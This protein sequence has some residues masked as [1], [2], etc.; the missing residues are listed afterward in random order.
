[1]GKSLVTG[2]DIGHH[3]IKAVVLKLAGDSYVLVGYKELFITEDI[4]SDNHTLDYQKIVK[5]LKE[6]RKGLPLFS[7]KV[8][9]SVPD[10]AVISKVLQID[11]DLQ[12]REKEFAIYQA[13]SHQSPFPIE[14]L[15]LDFVQ[16][17][18]KSV[19][20]SS[21]VSYQVYATRKDVVESRALAAQKA[22]FLPIAVDVQIHS[23]LN[24]WQLASR[25]QHRSDWMLMDVGHT[26]TALCIDFTDKAPFHK[27]IPLGCQCLSQDSAMSG[28]N[29]E[30]ADKNE[31]FVHELIERLQRQL[32]LFTSVNG[33]GSLAGIWLS[34][35]GADTPMLAQEIARRLKLEC[36]ILDPFLLFNNKLAKRQQGE[37]SGQSFST[38]AGLAMRGIEWLE[39]SHVA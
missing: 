2:I 23:L 5:K 28:T 14:E 30:L 18:E 20:R 11:S 24:I 19:S 34:G 8:A 32:Q 33:A 22:G 4:F 16:V 27:E 29:A 1:M 10:N 13:F 12:A 31:R 38:A 21:T 9:I 17:M 39:S 35:G 37:L 25:A 3:S 6:L 7:R 26:Q 36:E 15:S